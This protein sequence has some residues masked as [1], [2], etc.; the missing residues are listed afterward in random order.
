M[1]TKDEREQMKRESEA[2]RKAH[3][4]WPTPDD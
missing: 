3:P 1:I 4:D 2:R